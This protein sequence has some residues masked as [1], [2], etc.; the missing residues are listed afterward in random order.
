MRDSYPKN[1]ITADRAVSDGENGIRE[2]N[3]LDFPLE[4]RRGR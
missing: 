2:Q 3:C 1:L 4:D